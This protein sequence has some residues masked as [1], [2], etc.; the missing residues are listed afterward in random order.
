MNCDNFEDRRETQQFPNDQRTT[1]KTHVGKEVHSKCEM[2]VTATEYRMSTAMVLD[3]QANDS[4]NFR[5]F[6]LLSFG[7]AH[8]YLKMILK[9][10]SLPLRI[11]AWGQ[12]CLIYLNQNNI[13]QRIK[14]KSRYENLT[15]LS[16]I[17][18]SFKKMEINITILT[19][20][21]WENI[22]FSESRFLIN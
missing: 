5:N 14:C 3:S 18:K 13:V 6:C 17:V 22:Y 8:I 11:P 9:W 15:L 20:F 12:I 19:S 1:L 7:D 10:S 21:L 4:R 16:Q 2:G